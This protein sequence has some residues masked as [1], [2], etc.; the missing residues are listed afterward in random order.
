MSSSPPS[1]LLIVV[2]EAEP[3][4]EEHR[5]R[6]VPVAERGVPPHVT[7][8]YPFV[9]RDD[10]DDDVLRRVAATVAAHEAFAYGFTNVG[11]FDRDV[12][13]LAP[14]DPVPFTELTRALVAEFPEYPPYAGEYEDLSPHL[15]VA[16]ADDGADNGA[17]DGPDDGPDLDVVEAALVAGLPV[18]GRADHLTLMT[19]DD[20]GRWSV[21]RRFP[22]GRSAVIRPG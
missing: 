4:V 16:Y 21:A 18:A 2:P 8:L 6:F 7:A 11:W 20:E 14:D 12:L 9:A 1:A 3:V 5:L 19:E 22:L 15:T 17:D 10:L 13:Y